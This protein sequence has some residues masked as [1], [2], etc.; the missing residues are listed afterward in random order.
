[1]TEKPQ[2]SEYDRFKELTRKILKVPKS[3]IE[4]KPN[5]ST[6]VKKGRPAKKQDGD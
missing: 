1:M 5:V 3:E 6:G 4:G 2:K